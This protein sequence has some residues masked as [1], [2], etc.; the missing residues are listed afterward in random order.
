[1]NQKE[2]DQSIEELTE[3]IKPTFHTKELNIIEEIAKEKLNL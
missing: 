3:S 1:M 2:H